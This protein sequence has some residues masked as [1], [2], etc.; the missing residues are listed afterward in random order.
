[1]KKKIL[2]LI[3]AACGIGKSTLIDFLRDNKMIDEF[4]VVDTDEVGLNWWDDEDTEHRE[5]STIDEIKK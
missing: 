1:M 2:V 5:Q 4:C 3:C